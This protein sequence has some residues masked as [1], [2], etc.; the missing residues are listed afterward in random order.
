MTIHLNS[1]A[2]GPTDEEIE[3]EKMLS[4]KFN[5]GLPVNPKGKQ[6]VINVKPHSAQR[7]DESGKGV[8]VMK[9]NPQVV[10]VKPVN[11]ESGK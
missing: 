5:K 1:V 7:N 3:A 6:S 2:Y 10:T 9:P 4:T 8:K 11:V